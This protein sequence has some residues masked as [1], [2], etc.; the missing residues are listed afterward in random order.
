MYRRIATISQSGNQP[1]QHG[2]DQ[3]STETGAYRPTY[4]HP[5]K[6]IN[7]CGEIQLAI[8]KRNLRNIRSVILHMAVLHESRVKQRYPFRRNFS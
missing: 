4:N 2:I 3:I 8:R 1:I 7:H 6:A 5:I